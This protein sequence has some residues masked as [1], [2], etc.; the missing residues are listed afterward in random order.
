MHYDVAILLIFLV[1]VSGVVAAGAVAQS[2]RWRHKASWVLGFGIGQSC[3][4]AVLISCQDD[5]V[6]RFGVMVFGGMI[7]GAALLFLVVVAIALAM[8]DQS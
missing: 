2:R 3:V 7:S 1:A 5:P 8:K 6:E 4:S